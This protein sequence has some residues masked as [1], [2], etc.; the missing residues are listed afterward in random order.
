[1]NQYGYLTEYPGWF[2]NRRRF[3]EFVAARGFNVER[4][5]LV[6]EQPYVPN[7]PETAHYLGFLFRRSSS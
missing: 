6:A 5:F 1:M 7:A 2:M 4:E 3:I